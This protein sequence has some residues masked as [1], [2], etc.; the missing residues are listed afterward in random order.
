MPK[1][2][3]DRK[4]SWPEVR[5]DG[6]QDMPTAKPSPSVRAKRVREYETSIPG[7]VAKVVEFDRKF[8]DSP[9]RE[10]RVKRNKEL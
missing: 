5:H 4:P 9:Y 2:S 8:S 10:A 7:I 6:V 3:L 1:A